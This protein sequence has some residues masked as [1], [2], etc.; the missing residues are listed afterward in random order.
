MYRPPAA[1]AP[2]RNPYA[3]SH[4]YQGLQSY[5]SRSVDPLAQRPGESAEAW[6]RRVQSV[7]RHLPADEAQARLAAIEQASAVQS[8]EQLR[9]QLDGRQGN[10]TGIMGNATAQERAVALG[11][12]WG[13]R[14]IAG[15]GELAAQALATPGQA[16]P[17]YSNAEAYAIAR[18]REAEMRGQMPQRTEIPAGSS[19]EG[20]VVAR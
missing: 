14:E 17:T 2:Q 10:G 3:G 13:G 20:W 11:S 16:S 18:A 1:P 19:G 6:R 12:R 5:Q 4:A 8:H 7:I 15:Q 9:A